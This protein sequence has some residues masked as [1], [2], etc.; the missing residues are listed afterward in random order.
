MR[1]LPKDNCLGPVLVD[2]SNLSGKEVTLMNPTLAQT[3]RGCTMT[4]SALTRVK[5]VRRVSTAP[6]GANTASTNSLASHL[7]P[8]KGGLGQK[9]PSPQMGEKAKP[10][11]AT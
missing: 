5:L 9:C 4:L 8:P 6:R 7:A 11:A 3:Q 10:P 2:A 1:S